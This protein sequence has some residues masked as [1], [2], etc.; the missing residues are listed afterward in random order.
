MGSRYEF[1]LCWDCAL[2][3]S[4]KCPWAESGQPV[5][6]WKVRNTKIRFSRGE[7]TDSYHVYRCPLFVRD[8]KKGGMEKVALGGETNDKGSSSNKHSVT[9]AVY[10]MAVASGLGHLG[11]SDSA[12]ANCGDREARI[13]N[14]PEREVIDLAYGILERAVEDWKALEYGRKESA[15]IEKGSWVERSEVVGFFFSKW[16][17]RLCEPLHYSPEEI[18]AALNI[19]EEAKQWMTKQS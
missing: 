7:I 18:R 17:S 10:R 15:M 9:D 4:A 11:H 6:G 13:L 2:A 14:E 16:F 1:S 19:P 12:L 5:E 3:T 8:A